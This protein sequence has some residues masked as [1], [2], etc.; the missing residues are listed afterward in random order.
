[1]GY[2]EVPMVEAFS[3]LYNQ[4]KDV[5]LE[6]NGNY[7]KIVWEDLLFVRRSNRFYIYEAEYKQISFKEALQIWL[8]GKDPVF[9]QIKHDTANKKVKA[10]IAPTNLGGLPYYFFYPENYLYFVEK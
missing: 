3:Y 6:C 1:M 10:P 8:N 2:K 5:Y 4:D 7:T 9:Y